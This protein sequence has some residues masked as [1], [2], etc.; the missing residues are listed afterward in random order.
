MTDLQA[1]LES[2]RSENARLRKLLRLTHA[3]AAPAS[4]AR[5]L[6]KLLIHGRN[7]PSVDTTSLSTRQASSQSPMKAETKTRSR[8]RT[9]SWTSCVV[10]DTSG[11]APRCRHDAS[12]SRAPVCKLDNPY[13]GQEDSS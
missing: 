9:A 13:E 4:V 6:E 2:L 3:E 7:E 1:E 11:L 10:P 8:R 12:A 5:I